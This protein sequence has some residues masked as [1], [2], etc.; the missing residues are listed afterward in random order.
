MSS[1]DVIRVPVAHVPN[2]RAKVL[3]ALIRRHIKEVGP[4]PHGKG[5]EP[6]AAH[7]IRWGCAEAAK[8]RERSAVLN[9]GELEAERE[10][11]ARL[12]A[13]LDDAA[14]AL[15]AF[16]ARVEAAESALVAAKAQW[17]RSGAATV[18]PNED[19]SRHFV[20]VANG[21]G[22]R[23]KDARERCCL[24]QQDLATALGYKDRSAV[25]LAE[26]GRAPLSPSMAKWLEGQGR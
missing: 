25:S 18:D 16:A 22:A 8:P 7:V 24:S 6:S 1:D 2:F 19:K 21:D 5:G 4:V 11:S 3:P 26:R 14:R 20:P 23:L 12:T 13:E 15:F 10:K 17:A 9:S